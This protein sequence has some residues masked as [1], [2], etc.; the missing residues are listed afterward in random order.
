MLSSLMAATA[1]AGEGWRERNLGPDVP[2]ELIAEASAEDHATLV[3][4]SV[5]TERLIEHDVAGKIVALGSKLKQQGAALAVGGR[6]LPPRP[7][8]QGENVH[9]MGSMSELTAFARGLQTSAAK[10]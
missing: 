7:A 6:M 4:I 2:L 8:L 1:L 9:I 5:C 3:W 10:R